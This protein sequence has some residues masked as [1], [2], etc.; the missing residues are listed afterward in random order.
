[1]KVLSL[2]VAFTRCDELE[3]SILKLNGVRFALPASFAVVLGVGIWSLTSSATAPTDASWV[4][5]GGFFWAYGLLAVAAELRL[6]GHVRDRRTELAEL[7]R[8]VDG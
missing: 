2:D 4:W 7:R 8:W 5:F 3:R 1:M 6:R